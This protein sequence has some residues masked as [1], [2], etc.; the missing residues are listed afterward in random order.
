[1]GQCGSEKPAPEALVA[2]RR[3]HAEH[4]AAQNAGLSKRADDGLVISTYL[5]VVETQAEAGYVT[6]AMLEDQVSFRTADKFN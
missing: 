2:A 5:H 6:Y 1:M 4:E 3:L